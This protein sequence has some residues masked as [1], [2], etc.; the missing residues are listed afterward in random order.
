MNVPLKY[1]YFLYLLANVNNNQNNL[2]LCVDM[3]RLRNK[4]YNNPCNSHLMYC[5]QVKFCSRVKGNY[6]SHAHQGLYQMCFQKLWQ[7]INFLVEREY[8]LSW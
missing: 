6:F 8:S 4:V 1:T 7:L 5:S 3:D 2:C